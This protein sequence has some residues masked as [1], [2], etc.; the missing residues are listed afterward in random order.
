MSLRFVAAHVAVLTAATLAMFTGTSRAFAGPAGAVYVMANAAGPN[1]VVIYSRA[2]NGAL[3][4]SQS[5]MTGGMGTGAGLSSQG[6]LA[7]SQDNRWLFAVNA[8]SNDVTVFS[9]SAAGLTWASQTPSGG[10]M[11]ISVTVRNNTVFVLNAG[12]TPNI[13]GFHLTGAGALIPL[14]STQK[15][16]TGVG[17]AEV[18]LSPDG[19]LLVVSEKTSNTLEVFGINAGKVVGPFITASSGLEPFGF[20][21]GP[22]NLLVVSEA[23]NGVPDASSVSTYQANMGGG[24]RLITASLP[25]TQ[26]AACWLVV[27]DNG[28]LVFTDNTASATV[29][30]FVLNEDGSLHL[31]NGAAG[32]TPVGTSPI[33]LTLTAGNQYLYSLASGTISG[34]QI[35]SDGSLTPIGTVMGL[36]TSAVGLVAF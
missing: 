1:A 11:P 25:T 22:H 2:A 34:F 4:Q 8:G 30:S 31:L 29:S 9:I 12:G 3:G 33:D 27:S 10:M 13:A 15:T 35:A 21:F 6:S 23:D 17:A 7:I 14:P 20:A 28:R 5:V 16:L 32:S 36:P 24:L 18:S 26:T 19:S